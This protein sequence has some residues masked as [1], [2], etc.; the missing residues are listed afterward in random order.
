MSPEV[1]R[2]QNYDTKVDMWSTGIMTMEMM[3]G[4]PPYMEYPP[5]RALFLITTK[6]I[7]PVAQ[8]ELWSAEIKDFLDKCL[9]RA[10]ENR[11][12]A[13]TLLQHPFL[14]KACSMS[15]LAPAIET[16]RNLKNSKP[17]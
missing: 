7:P 16:A 8:P 5:L 6:G 1:I 2:G 14:K 15:G 9:D 13:T 17:Y 12:D 4:E 10:P 11:P 3:E